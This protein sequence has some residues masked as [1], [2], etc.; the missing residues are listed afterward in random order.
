MQKRGRRRAAA[1][2]GDGRI[3]R[4]PGQAAWRCVD[5]KSPERIKRAFEYFISK[6]ALDIDGVGEKVAHMLIDNGLVQTFDDLFTL[7]VGDFEPLPGFAEISAKKA[8]DAVQKARKNVPLHR[9]ITGLSIDHVGEE[10]ARDLAEHF[11]SIA[12]LRAT[13]LEKLVAMEGVGEKVAHSIVEWFADKN[14]ST[15]IDRLLAHITIQKPALRQSQG[16]KL[17][18][19]GK[20]FVFTGSMESMSREEAGEKVRA[21]G[22]EVSGSVSKKT[23]YVVSGDRK[24]TRLNSSH[25]QIS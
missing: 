7:E 19:S 25:S 9:L 11:G 18:L 24:S 1:C 21:L 13:T 4:V 2:G 17:P 10:T 14:N 15:M 3:E 22:G 6:K 8:Y 20:T 12:K 16:E 23:S 5:R